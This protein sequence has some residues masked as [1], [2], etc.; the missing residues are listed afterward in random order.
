[1]DRYSRGLPKD[2]KSQED[3]ELKVVNK[4]EDIL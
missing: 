3:I 4:L 1:M 2:Y